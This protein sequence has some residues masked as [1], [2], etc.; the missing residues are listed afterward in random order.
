MS[1]KKLAIATLLALPI[2]V[3]MVAHAAD[4]P[5]DKAIKARQAMYQLYSFNMGILSA[6]AK[7]KMDYNAEVAAEAATNLHAAAHLGQSQ[8]WPQGSDNATDGNARTRALPAIWE[9]FPA[10]V[11]KS[12]ALKA[13]TTVLAAEAGNGLAALKGAIG[14]VGGSCKG[15]HDDY[16]AEKK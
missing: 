9:T 15:C 12:D 14:D 7:D 1:L 4:G 5:H 3:V 2:S 6:M 11:E 8:F 13:S 10:I 16:R